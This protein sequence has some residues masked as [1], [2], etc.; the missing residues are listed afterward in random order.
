MEV[1]RLWCRDPGWLDE[2]SQ[3]TQ[4]Q[5]MAWYQIRLQKGGR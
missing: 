4:A 1:E 2:Q 5:L 3:E